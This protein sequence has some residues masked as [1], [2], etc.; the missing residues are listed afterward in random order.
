MI[1]NFGHHDSPGERHVN[2]KARI[3]VKVRGFSFPYARPFACSLATEAQ[4]EPIE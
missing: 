3:S 2:A 1:K 4:L